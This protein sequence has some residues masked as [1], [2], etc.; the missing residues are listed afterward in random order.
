MA[1]VK[2][3]LGDYVFQSVDPAGTVTVNTSL[4]TISGNLIVLGNSSSIDTVNTTFYDNFITLN[5]NIPQTAT[6]TINAGINVDRGLMPNV[7]MQW[8]ETML[9]W[10]VTTDGTNFGNIVV[11]GPNGGLRLDANLNMRGYTIYDSVT[12]QVTIDTNLAMR[13]TTVA[14][15]TISGYSLISSQPV[16]GGG[17]GLYVTNTTVSNQELVTKSKAIV[18]SLIM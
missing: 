8:N 9:R 14:P 17:S 4:V 11:E 1:I 12:T 18:Y 13:T 10:Q 5:A 15:G 2:N 16:S 3:V 7:A 6:P